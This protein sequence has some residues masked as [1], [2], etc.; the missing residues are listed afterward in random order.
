M[1]LPRSISAT[2]PRER[3]AGVVQL[4]HLQLIAVLHGA[5]TLNP[6]IT[7]HSWGLIHK[8]SVLLQKSASHALYLSK[9]GFEIAPFMPI[10]LDL[11][12]YLVIP[13]GTQMGC[14]A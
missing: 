10:K 3:P 4:L 8:Q 1:P 6:I 12:I 9:H 14:S 5:S 11:D 13:L 7:P 2:R